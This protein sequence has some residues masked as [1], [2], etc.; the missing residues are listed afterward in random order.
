MTTAGR[1][2]RHA[3]RRAALTQRELAAA[4]D[5]PQATVG[6]IEA[7]AVQP[8]VDTLASLLRATGH[9]LEIGPLMGQGVDRTQI[10]E[11]LRLTPSER[12]ELA[13]AEA[14]RMPALRVRRDR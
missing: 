1:L 5:V 10:R 8:R 12:I 7:G 14:R 6:R 4:A 9:E 11:R 3:R 13:A 2:L